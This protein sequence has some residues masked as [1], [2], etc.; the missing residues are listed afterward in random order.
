MRAITVAD[1]AQRARLP[2]MQVW[3]H[4]HGGATRLKPEQRRR[5][6]EAMQ[7][8]RRELLERLLAEDAQVEAA[9]G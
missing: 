7:E 4:L 5:I 2:Y 1:I 3:R 9:R 8:L 6:E